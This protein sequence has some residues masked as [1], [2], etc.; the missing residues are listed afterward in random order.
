M[1]NIYPKSWTSF[2]L[3]DICFYQEGPGLRNWQYEETGIKFINIRCIKDEYLDLSNAQ[4][5]SKDEVESKYKHFLL[6]EGDYVL[7]SSGTIGRIAVVREYDLP[8]LLNTSVIRFRSL[9]QSK[10]DMI[11]LFYFL[12]S[13]QFFEKIYEQSQGSAQVN[14]GPTHLNVLKANFPPL[15]EQKKIADILSSM[16]QL[17]NSTAKWSYTF[18]GIFSLPLYPELKNSEVNMICNKLIKV[19][20]KF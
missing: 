4:F 20:K 15:S 12:Q 7:S 14:F 6:N 10:L 17:I 18:G 9:D 3:K 1:N 5:I 19:L 16:D 11:F 13:N 8:L 2:N